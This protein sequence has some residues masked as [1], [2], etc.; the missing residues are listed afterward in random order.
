[1]W[2]L[3]SSTSSKARERLDV[4]GADEVLSGCDTTMPRNLE[5]QIH[6]NCKAFLWSKYKYWEGSDDL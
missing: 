2:Q 3:S 5:P 6:G 4:W 1:M